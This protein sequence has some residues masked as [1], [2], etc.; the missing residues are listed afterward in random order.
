M[1]YVQSSVRS[2]LH[3][4]EDA[5]ACRGSCKTNIKVATEGTRLAIHRLHLVHVAVYILTAGVYA[6]QVELLQQLQRTQRQEH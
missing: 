4:S 5:R 2:A 1:W 6:I 3:C